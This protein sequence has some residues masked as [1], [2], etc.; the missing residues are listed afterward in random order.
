MVKAGLSGRELRRCR[1]VCGMLSQTLRFSFRIV[2]KTPR[3]IGGSSRSGFTQSSGFE[4]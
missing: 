2:G 4:F 1:A 3:G